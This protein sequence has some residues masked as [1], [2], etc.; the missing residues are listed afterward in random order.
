MFTKRNKAFLTIIAC[1]MTLT[2]NA[3]AAESRAEAEASISRQRAQEIALQRVNGGRIVEAEFNDR[4][5]RDDDY[6]F[7]VVDNAHRYTISVDAQTGEILDVKQEAIFDDNLSTN[8]RARLETGV[9]AAAV[10][11][12]SAA[13][14]AA[15]SAAATA[16]NA[17]DRAANVARN[18]AISAENA[19]SSAARNAAVSVDK[20]VDSAAS[21][22][23]NAAVSAENAASRAARNAALDTKSGLGLTTTG[24]ITPE[25]ARAIAM[26]R[27]PNGSIVEMERNM[28]NDRAVYDIEMIS[29]TRK[30][31]LKVDGLTGRVISYDED[32]LD[33]EE[34]MDHVR[35]IGTTTNTR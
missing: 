32:R 8:E 11:A 5:F 34:R 33:Q 27:V 16:D 4:W 14:S 12:G 15:R 21:A 30:I 25:R 26:D 20:A 9:G 24:A 28:D 3:F 17:V 19:A 6:E 10:G 23:R 1:T 13:A 31:D 7:V 2:L 18:A 22:T 35:P 29:S